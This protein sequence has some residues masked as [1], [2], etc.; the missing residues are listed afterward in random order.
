M[1]PSVSTQM[2]VH[3]MAETQTE[4]MQ[5]AMRGKRLAKA[6][7]PPPPPPSA[8]KG[9]PSREPS[10]VEQVRVRM[11]PDGRMTRRDAALYLGKSVKTLAEWHTKGTGPPSVLVGGTR[12][13][14]KTN[15]DEF[16]AGGQRP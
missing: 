15:L 7:A 5:R 10:A 14:Y 11:T 6:P 8:A 12:F 4:I 9:K 3:P 16:I 1:F 2:G 13:Y